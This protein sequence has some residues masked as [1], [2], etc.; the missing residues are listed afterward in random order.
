MSNGKGMSFEILFIYLEREYLII[1]KIELLIQGR[2]YRIITTNKLV[3][4]LNFDNNMLNFSRRRVIFVC[5]LDLFKN[6]YLF[7]LQ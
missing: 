6:I 7:L 3:S 5:L 1:K 2:V 4:S